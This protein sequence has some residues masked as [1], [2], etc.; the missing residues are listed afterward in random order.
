MFDLNY[1]NPYN[2]YVT[3]TQEFGNFKFE[4]L[5][6]EGLVIITPKI[7]G[8]SRGYFLET[9]NEYAFLNAGIPTQFKQDNQSYSSKGVLRG[10]HIQNPTFQG[11]LVRCNSGLVYD[12]AI[13]LRKGSKTFGHFAGILL[14]P[15]I[16]N[17]F[18]VP[19]GFAHGFLALEDSEFVYK[20]SET[21][22]PNEDLTVSYD[23]FGAPWLDI[24]NKYDI[25]EF[26]TS[27]KDRQNAISVEQYRVMYCLE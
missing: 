15:K 14:D 2:P 7:Y 1:Q 16:K 17:M 10:M 4:S 9:Y 20:C 13:D 5:S 24:A 26:L 21:W 25:S 22:K 27:V 11:K 18:Y 19:E 8:D 12:V 23:C 6:I 3:K